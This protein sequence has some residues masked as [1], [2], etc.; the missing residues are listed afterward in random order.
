MGRETIGC[1]QP[2]TEASKNH[3]GFIWPYSHSFCGA[4]NRVRVTAE[5]QLLLRLGRNA[6]P[7]CGKRAHLSIRF[8]V[9]ILSLHA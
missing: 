5:G 4:C 9:Y 1:Q 2:V 7:I 6:R 3:V 8:S